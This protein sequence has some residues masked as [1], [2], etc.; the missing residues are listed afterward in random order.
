MICRL[1]V[2]TIAIFALQSVLAAE[3]SEASNYRQ[4]SEL[5]SSSG[6]PDD[7]QLAHAAAQEFERV[8]YLSNNDSTAEREENVVT[9]L[10]MDFVY[11]PV[12]FHHPTVSDFRLFATTMN[13]AGDAK[14]LLHCDVNLRASTFSFLYRVAVLDVPVA[15]AKKDLDSVWTPDETWFRF[16]RS[17]LEGYG[18]SHECAGCDWGEH[19]FIDD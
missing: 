7:A 6:Q 2:I 14:T 4:Y 1:V 19:E 12:D 8:I 9:D 17:V 16:L 3:I 15:D 13:S 18:R 11:I 5:L 10:G